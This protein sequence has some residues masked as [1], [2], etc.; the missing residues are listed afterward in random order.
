LPALLAVTHSIPV[1][2]YVTTVLGILALFGGAVLKLGV[3]FKS[4]RVLMLLPVLLLSA[5]AA[6]IVVGI[7]FLKGSERHLPEQ[8]AAAVEPDSR[9][10][11]LV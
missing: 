11:R 2:L 10:Q 8:L 4:A 5:W 9:D 1:A 6:V 3:D 7:A